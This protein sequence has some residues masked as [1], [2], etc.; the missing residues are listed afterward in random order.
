[1]SDE[2]AKPTRLEPMIADDVSAPFWDATREQKLVLQ[3]CDDC[4]RAIHYP[5]PRCPHCFGTRLSWRDARGTG[6]IYAVSVM[7]QPG[8]PL[9]ESRLPYAVALVDLDEGTR[10]LSNIVGDDA[11][12]APVGA[13]VTVTWEPLSDGKHLPLFTREG[14]R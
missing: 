4:N 3:W 6:T 13:R 5:R 10:M 9:M 12:D 1:V 11:L 14:N 8:N 2:Q 7:H